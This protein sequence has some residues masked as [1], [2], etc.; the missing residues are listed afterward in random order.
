MNPMNHS[1]DFPGVYSVHYDADM[2]SNS[3]SKVC[4]SKPI[5]LEEIKMIK[6]KLPNATVN[7]ALLWGNMQVVRRIC[8]WHPK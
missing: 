3:F 6:S 5:D 4:S 8:F 7:D 1:F 2:I